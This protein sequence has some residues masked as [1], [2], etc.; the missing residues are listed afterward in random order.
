[1]GR[2]RLKGPDKR[3]MLQN[4]LWPKYTNDKNMIYL[5]YVLT[6]LK[7]RIYYIL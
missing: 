2:Y 7:K 5:V 6:E 3:D 4:L 1:M